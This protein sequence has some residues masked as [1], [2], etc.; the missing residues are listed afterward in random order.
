MTDST[1]TQDRSVQATVYTIL[2]NSIMSFQLKPGT[3][4]STQ[5]IATKLQVSRTPVREAF[6]RLQRDG[7]VDIF[8]Q[9]ETIVSRIDLQRVWQERFI[10][11]ALECTV[12]DSVAANRTAENLAPLHANIEMQQKV[13]AAGDYYEYMR[14]DNEFHHLLFTI[15]G[16]ELAWE[17]VMDVSSHYAR[18]RFIA[19]WTAQIMEKNISQHQLLVSVVEEGSAEAARTLMKKHLH[20]LETEIKD[21]AVKY[22]DFFVSAENSNPARRDMLL[23]L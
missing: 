13:F 22:P 11:E 10:R 12:L 9:K 17:T 18:V 3:V 8:P 4:M 20:Q 14:L 2:K 1:A 7:L 6:I 16:Q 5:E 21:I 23:S 19:V 15:G